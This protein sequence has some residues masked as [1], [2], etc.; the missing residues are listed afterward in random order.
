MQMQD[1]ILTN[2]IFEAA[3]RLH[4]SLNASD[5]LAEAMRLFPDLLDAESWAVY[6]KSE[7]ADRLELVRA[8]NA[9]ALPSGPFVDLDSVASPIARAVTE[10]SVV[11]TQSN[12]PCAEQKVDPADKKRVEFNV[13]LLVGRRLVGVLQATRVTSAGAGQAFSREETHGIEIVCQSLARSLANAIDYHT[14]TRQTLIDDL[15]RLYNVRYLYQTLDNEIRRA[16]RYGSPVSVVFMDLDGF[17]LIND[18]Y[19]HRAGSV[20][21]TEVARVIMLSVREADFV[22]RYGGDEFVMMLPETSARSAL[23]VAERVRA[24]IA[25]HRFNGGVGAD[26]YLT[27]SFGI[28]SFPEHATEA[29]KLIELADAAMYKAKQ[30]EKNTVRLAAT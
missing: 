2:S 24:Q 4:E 20:T 17:K 29:E 16:R 13:P 15:T 9:A 11:I 27:A 22:A 26:I 14:A 3:M 23:Q 7:Q 8:I 21:L 19:G 28:A 10:R 5:I 18:A 6:L 1:E 12:A 25:A 30:F